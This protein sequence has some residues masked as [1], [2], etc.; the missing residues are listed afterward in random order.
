MKH[1]LMFY[2]F[3]DDYLQRREQYRDLHLQHAWDAQRQGVLLLGG[4]LTEPTDGG[5]LLFQADSPETVNE[6]ARKDPYV[7][8]G[9]VTSF[10]VREWLTVVGT[11]AR[12]PIRP[13]DLAK[14]GGVHHGP[15]YSR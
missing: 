10:R 4:A 15:E 12:K 6:F 1:F 2:S 7:V 9:L 8:N 13:E 3:V 5:V 14:A 11:Q